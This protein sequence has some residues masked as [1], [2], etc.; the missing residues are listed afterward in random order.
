MSQKDFST[1]SAI[2]FG[3]L[4]LV[5]VLAFN[6]YA[7]VEPSQAPPGGNV[8]VPI[9]VGIS[10]QWKIGKLGVA[11]D[12]IDTSYGLTVG[13]GIKVTNTSS[14][15]TLYLEDESGDSTP[16]VIDASGNVGI[17]TTEPQEK[18]HVAG[19]IALSNTNSITFW[20]GTNNVGVITGYGSYNWGYNLQ[21]SP[22]AELIIGSGE[23]GST[24]RNNGW[25]NGNS[26]TLFIA[27]DQDIQFWSDLQDAASSDRV[28]T[29]TNTGNVGIGTTDPQGKLDISGGPLAINGN[30]GQSGQFLKSQ[31]PGQPPIWASVG[32]VPFGGDGSDGPLDLTTDTTIDLGGAAVFIKNYTYINIPSGVTLSFTNPHDNGTIIIFKSQGDVTI[33]GTINLKNIGGRG[34]N[35]GFIQCYNST[36]HGILS[37]GGGYLGSGGGGARLGCYNWHMAFGGAGG[38]NKTNGGNGELSGVVKVAGYVFGITPGNALPPLRLGIILPGGGGSGGVVSGAEE[39]W[40]VAYGNGGRGAGALKIECNGSL[41]FTGNI[42]ADGSPGESV[43][44]S[45]MAAGGGGGAGGSVW[46]QYKNLI[47]NTGTISVNGGNGGKA[48]VDYEIDADGGAGSPGQILIEEY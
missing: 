27:S 45:R 28:M 44:E 23:S 11:I 22:G 33:S 1:L 29:I 36:R 35:G 41:N 25:A 9:N 16:F 12:G 31:G 13:S 24:L 14:N 30:V 34:G 43:S 15:P 18:L 37:D 20:D 2:T 5:F 32:G 19:N 8:P 26:E 48:T 40:N 39:S 42:N 38:G 6:I 21:V 10:N 7:W 4:V 47:A 17:G 3:I 46:I